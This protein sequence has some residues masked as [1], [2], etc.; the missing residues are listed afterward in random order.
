[1]KAIGTIIIGLLFLTANFALAQDS[2]Y[3]YKTGTIIYKQAVS[4]I[5]SV[6]FERIFPVKDI[7]GNIYH[8]V[9]IGTQIWMVENLRTTRY[10]DGVSIPL[11]SE[12]SSWAMLNT[13]GYCWQ[14]NDIANKKLYGALYNWYAVDMGKLCP[15]GWH[16]PTDNE[17]ITLISYLGGEAIAGGKLKESGLAHWISPNTGATNETGFTALPGNSRGS[18]G[19]YNQIG[20]Y[21]YWWT[22]TSDNQSNAVLRGMYY[23]KSSIDRSAL[24]KEFGFSVRCIKNK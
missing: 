13:P 8:T 24:S 19:S 11:V 23:P 4:N 18:D 3:V 16:V 5:D 14:N 10:N 15:S 17:W 21:G 12:N 20:P 7:D 9:K 6:T 2:L 22:S 1:M